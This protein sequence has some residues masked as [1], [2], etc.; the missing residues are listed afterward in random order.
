MSLVVV[1]FKRYDQDPPGHF[2][3]DAIDK[4][5]EDVVSGTGILGPDRSGPGY[6]YYYQPIMAVVRGTEIAHSLQE[7][8]PV[9]QF[10]I[11]QIPAF[12]SA[13]AGIVSAWCA[14]RPRA[15]N[16]QTVPGPALTREVTITIGDQSYTGTPKNEKEL[17][18]ILNFL[19][20]AENYSR[21]YRAARTAQTISKRK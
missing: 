6:R 9:L 2:Y 5:I 16:D 11:E 20:K 1:K 10:V 4:M 15:T 7:D 13:F 18:Q 17:Q 21:Y 8:G 19:K 14:W 12:I 3:G